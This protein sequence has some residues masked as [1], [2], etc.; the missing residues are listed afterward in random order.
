M[1]RKNPNLPSVSIQVLQR[2]LSINSNVVFRNIINDLIDEYNTEGTISEDSAKHLI[3]E[4]P[5]PPKA[6]SD[7]QF[8]DAWLIADKEYEEKLRFIR[9]YIVKLVAE[10]K[11]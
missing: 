10:S 8:I 4:R 11:S 7:T 9:Q 6:S 2:E 1:T 5:K 3:G